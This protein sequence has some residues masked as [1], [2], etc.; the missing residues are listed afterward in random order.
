M[1]VVFDEVIATVET[2][3]TSPPV[4][5]GGESEQ[6]A[7]NPAERFLQLMDA[8]KRRAKRLWAD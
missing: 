5:Q 6:S 1:S 7:G 8:Q 4:Q 3:D 2:P